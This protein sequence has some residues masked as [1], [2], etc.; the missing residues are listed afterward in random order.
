MYRITSP[1]PKEEYRTLPYHVHPVPKQD[2]PSL[3]LLIAKANMT[4]DIKS[5]L[6]FA[7]RPSAQIQNSTKPNQ[8]QPPSHSPKTQNRGNVPGGISGYST[9]YS[10]RRH[11]KWQITLPCIFQKSRSNPSARPS[12]SSVPCSLLDRTWAWALLD[13]GWCESIGFGLEGPTR[14]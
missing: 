3:T 10:S 2:Q 6:T 4:R 5:N 9:V 13:L 14:R 11:C 12:D 8:A 1:V 7:S